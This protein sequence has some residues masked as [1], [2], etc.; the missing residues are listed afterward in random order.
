MITLTR[1]AIGCFV[2]FLGLPQAR[3]AAEDQPTDGEVDGTLVKRAATL[4]LE[5]HL[6]Q[7]FDPRRVS[8]V[9]TQQFLLALDPHRMHFLASDETEFIRQTHQGFEK[10]EKAEKA[11]GDVALAMRIAKR[12]RSRFDTNASYIDTLLT[13]THDF[14]VDEFVRTRHDDFASNENACKE[15]WRLRIK[16]ELLME[17]PSN[18]NGNRSR[19]FLRGRYSRIKTHV[20]SLTPSRVLSLYI[21]SLAKTLDPHSEYY[22]A[23]FL[24]LFNKG[25]L[26]EFTIALPFVFRDGDLWIRSVPREMAFV[27]ESLLGYRIVAVRVRGK[28]PIH[29]TGLSKEAALRTIVSPV[30]ELGCANQVILDLDHPRTGQRRVVVCDRFRN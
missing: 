27:D 13:K 7:D 14:T 21:D 11:E 22:A 8:E 1:I 9:W 2:L 4:L 26:S 6:R 24:T 16:Y 10:V 18:P 15:R 25:V 3:V 30:A 23:S 20:R 12:F 28:S 29:L 17:A 5:T 19:E